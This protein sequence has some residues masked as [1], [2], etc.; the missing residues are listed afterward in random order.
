MDN[1]NKLKFE[2]PI[3]EVITFSE[4]DIITMSDRIPEMPPVDII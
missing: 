2:E 3:I 1:V 4:D